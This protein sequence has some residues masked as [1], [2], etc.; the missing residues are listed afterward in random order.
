MILRHEQAED[1]EAGGWVVPAHAGPATGATAS[2]FTAGGGAAGTVVTTV[3]TS[4]ETA[5]DTRVT[6]SVPSIVVVIEVTVLIFMLSEFGHHA[7]ERN[8]GQ[9]GAYVTGVIVV[10]TDVTTGMDR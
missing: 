7:T 6:T 1:K 2:R 10:V 8:A 3:T 9:W 5:V 4:V